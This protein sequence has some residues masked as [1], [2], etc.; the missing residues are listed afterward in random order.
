MASEYKMM[1]VA[2]FGGFIFGGIMPTTASALVAG[3]IW[4]IVCVLLFDDKKKS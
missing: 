1:I 4:G 3:A 2:A